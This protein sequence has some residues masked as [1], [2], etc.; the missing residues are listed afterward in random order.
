MM[1]DEVVE[2]VR[3]VRREIEEA[4]GGSTEGLCRHYREYQKALR[5]RMVSLGPPVRRLDVPE[6][7]VPAGTPAGSSAR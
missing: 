3:K 1:H 5:D 7:R 6:P 2:E 4:A